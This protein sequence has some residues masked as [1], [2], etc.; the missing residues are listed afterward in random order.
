[1]ILVTGIK[2]FIGSES[3]RYLQEKGYDVVGTSVDIRDKETLRPYFKNIEFVIHA[4]GK[5]KKG[6]P[7]QETYYSTNV[8]GTRNVVDLCLENDS[9]LIHLSSVVSDGPFVHEI[10]YAISKLA[11][12]NLVEDYSLHKNLRA[13]N[14]KLCVIYD[15]QNNTK[16]SGARYPIEKLLLDIENIIKNND[17]SKYKLVD[18]SNT[19]T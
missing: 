4:A 19:R 11:S 18:Y 9:K 1:M 7:D 15:S 5:V 10:P 16:R 17:F 3:L 14:L 6:I 12:Q 8:I 13:I 2:G